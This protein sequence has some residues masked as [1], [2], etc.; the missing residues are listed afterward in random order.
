PLL[1]FLAAFL[2]N[3]SSRN[4]LRRS[5]IHDNAVVSYQPH[6]SASACPGDRLEAVEGPLVDQEHVAAAL[7]APVLQ[8]FQPG[9]DG[10]PESRNG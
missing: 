4:S 1:Q 5:A 7:S 10:R 6:P 9:V 2:R 3:V 8:Q